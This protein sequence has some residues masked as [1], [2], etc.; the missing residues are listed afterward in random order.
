MTNKME[1]NYVKVGDYIIIQRQNYTKLHKVTLKGTVMLGKDQLELGTIIG[2]PVWKTYKMEPKKNGKRVFVLKECDKYESLAEQLKKDVSSGSD[3]RNIFDDGRSQLLSTE[4]IIGLRT[5]GLSGQAI[6]GQLIENSKTF[7]DKTEYSQEKYLKKKEKK[8]F[9][10][11]TVRWPTIRLISEVMYRTDPVKIM[12]LRMDTLSQIL[13][14]VGMHS[15]G[16]YMLYESGCQG[17]VASAMLNNISIGGRLLHIH[18]GNLPQKQAIYA[19]NYS[20]DK[21]SCLI[22]VNIYS[23]LRKLLQEN[24]VQNENGVQVP[25]KEA[26]VNEGFV[27]ESENDGGVI[28]TEDFSSDVMHRKESVISETN[29]LNDKLVQDSSRE[30]N[31]IVEEKEIALDVVNEKKRKHSD[32]DENMSKKPRWEQETEKAADFL[33]LSKAD[34]LVIV[35]REHP[36]NILTALLPYIA[37]SRPFIV[38]CPC[39][40]PLLELY[41]QLKGKNSTVGLRV[42]ETWLRSHQVL[43]SRTHPDILMSGGGGYLLSGIVVEGGTSTQELSLS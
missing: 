28:K 42:T 15:H 21:M 25:K 14:I 33:R 3:N 24:S 26:V 11:I 37:P 22:S 43:P 40:E 20:S 31:E 23:F 5:S 13:T 17:L 6:V 16:M 18:P 38:Y 19:M 7:R 12:G 36:A 41:V 2:R 10:Y 4:E 8:Y 27:S 32:T 35:A 34:G 9:E 30:D 1:E 39:R 29:S